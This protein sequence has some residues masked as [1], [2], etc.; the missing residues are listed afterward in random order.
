MHQ[1]M[2]SIQSGYREHMHVILYLLYLQVCYHYK[3][4]HVCE[5][6][7]TEWQ[8]WARMYYICQQLLKILSQNEFVFLPLR[9]QISLYCCSAQKMRK[10]LESC[11]FAWSLCRHEHSQ[12]HS[13]SFTG[14]ASSF[15]TEA[16]EACKELSVD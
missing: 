5:H 1:H 16:F 3:L 15:P 14:D 7:L 13:V 8:N 9:K 11:V 12:Y 6:G 2:Q 10:F 4:N